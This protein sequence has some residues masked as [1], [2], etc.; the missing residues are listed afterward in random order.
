ML[1]SNADRCELCGD[2]SSFSCFD[3][4]AQRRVVVTG[5]GLVTPVG[6]GVKHAWSNLLKGQCGISKLVGEEYEK[7]PV[8][9]A[10]Q[11]PKGPKEQGQFTS[12]E[13]LD[14]GVS[15][16]PSTMEQQQCLTLLT[17]RTIVLW[18]RLHNMLL[19]LHVKH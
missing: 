6:V 12:S 1:R 14:R 17:C 2:D 18:E 16:Y 19:Q 8:Q 15:F 7:L 11:V 9:I 10:A 3:I 13:W 5:L 4:M